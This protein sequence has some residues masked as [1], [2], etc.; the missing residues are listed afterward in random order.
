[1]NVRHT[2][3]ERE[4]HPGRKVDTPGEGV[5]GGGWGLAA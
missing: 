2:P 1:L 4:T 5:W 3:D